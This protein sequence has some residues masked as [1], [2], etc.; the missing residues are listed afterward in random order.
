[1]FDNMVN[2]SIN[3]ESYEISMYPDYGICDL[4]EANIHHFDQTVYNTGRV[5]TWDNK[6]TRHTFVR[7]EEEDSIVFA[8]PSGEPIAVGNIATDSPLL[9]EINSIKRHYAWYNPRLLFPRLLALGM[10]GYISYCGLSGLSGSISLDYTSI[11]HTT[12][13]SLG[14]TGILI[15]AA[16][17]FRNATNTASPEYEALNDRNLKKLKEKRQ[18]LL[19]FGPSYN[20]SNDALGAALNVSF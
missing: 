14:L 8:S 18:M 4:M 9:Q 5:S 13:F 1:M 12:M 15:S 7:W 3:Y 2:S 16:F 17:L 6:T 11:R 10:C 20:P 19:A